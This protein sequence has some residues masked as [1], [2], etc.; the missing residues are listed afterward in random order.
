MAPSARGLPRGDAPTG[1]WAFNA[2]LQSLGRQRAW[3]EAL[4]LLHD[5]PSQRLQP[6]KSTCSILLRACSEASRWQVSIQLLSEWTHHGRELD[7]VCLNAAIAACKRGSQW[8][9]ALKT[10]L[11]MADYGAVADAV[12]Y[13]SAMGACEKSSNW[14]MALHLF[15]DMPQHRIVP[16]G[17]ACSGALRAVAEGRQWPVAFGLLWQLLDS[18]VEVNG[19]TFS[20]TLQSLKDTGR[21]LLALQ[22]L[23]EMEP[24]SVGKD[25]VSYNTAMTACETSGQ[26][27]AALALLE[28]L[29]TSQLSPDR[30]SYGAVL[31]SCASGLK[32]QLSCALLASAEERSLRGDNHCHT[33]AMIAC[34]ECEE[35]TSALVLLSGLQRS[36]ASLDKVSFSAALRACGRGSMWQLAVFLLDSMIRRKLTPDGVHVGDAV[37][38]VREACGE[39]EALDY[40][41][42][43]RQPWGALLDLPSSRPV[44]K[45]PS[46]V[47]Q[48]P[49]FAFSKPEGISTEDFVRSLARDL[50]PPHTPPMSIT[51]PSRLDYPTS[52]VLPIALGANS[53]ASNWLISQFAARLVKK[54]YLCLCEGP[55]MTVGEVGTISSPLLTEEVGEALVTRVSPLGREA[56]TEYT[57]AESFTKPSPAAEDQRLSLL[58]V[59]LLTGRTHQ[60][61]VHLASIGQPLV[62]DRTYGNRNGLPCARM[63]LHCHKVSFRNFE[64]SILEA[65]A[66]LP[67]E[68]QVLLDSLER[69]KKMRRSFSSSVKDLLR[70]HQMIGN[71][72]ALSMTC[73]ELF[74]HDPVPPEQVSQ[75]L[76]GMLER[77]EL[78]TMLMDA[79]ASAMEDADQLSIFGP[80]LN[81]VCQRL[82][83]RNLAGKRKAFQ[84]C[85]DIDP[86]LKLVRSASANLAKQTGR[87]RAVARAALDALGEDRDQACRLLLSGLALAVLDSEPCE[88]ELLAKGIPVWLKAS[89]FLGLLGV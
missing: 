88:V 58:K 74:G 54:E 32:W 53:F 42:R 29:L 84:P 38:C 56:G 25:L 67:R 6:D 5:L 11:T 45:V 39:E 26:W 7:V 80:I 28:T 68:L 86:S 64:G 33:A 59:R 61:R 23:E 65:V 13:A 18:A 48:P 57:V 62:G 8:Q 52:G 1:L 31:R 17:I 78:T 41:L 9:S 2:L 4:S 15:C 12:T 55:D 63:F 51:G 77:R 14:Q 81:Q 20:S 19:Y 40:L 50:A 47:W 24:R 21:W 76:S 70:V 16:D 22:T 44:A 66:Q 72:G 69:K 27:Q 79:M 85:D 60:I 73:S 83:G 49:F 75:C 87:P 71:Y 3:S 30:F 89:R 82:K 36:G 10:L 43:L 35:W 37:S 46:L 34:A